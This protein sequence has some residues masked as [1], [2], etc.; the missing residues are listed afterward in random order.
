GLASDE[1]SRMQGSVIRTALE[2]LEFLRDHSGDDAETGAAAHPASRMAG[3]PPDQLKRVDALRS[4]RARDPTLRT[5][6]LEAWS[7]DERRP[8][9]ASTSR[10]A[11]KQLEGR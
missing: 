9:I 1:E 7:A 8:A 3:W 6:L 10:W 2:R 4:L 5:K 11:L